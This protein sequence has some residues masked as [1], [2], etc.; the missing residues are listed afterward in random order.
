M[1]K[2]LRTIDLNNEVAC[3]V[4]FFENSCRA[5]GLY[6]RFAVTECLG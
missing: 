2:I 6:A 5:R 1:T 3:G 4:A